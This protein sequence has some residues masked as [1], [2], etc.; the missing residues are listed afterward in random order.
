MEQV[1][2]VAHR[3]LVEHSPIF[4]AHG[5]NDRGVRLVASSDDDG[6]FTARHANEGPTWMQAEYRKHGGSC[7]IR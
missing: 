3:R 2:G 7:R 6:D 1:A 4:A 5:C